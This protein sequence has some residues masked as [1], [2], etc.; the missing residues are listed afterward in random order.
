MPSQLSRS[1]KEVLSSAFPN[2]LILEEE[3][4]NY[5]GQRLFFD[6]F[7]PTLEIYVEVQGIQHTQFSPHFHA[8][9]GAFRAQKKRDKLKL[10]WCE[11][12]GK[13]LVSVNYDEVEGLTVEK[14]LE[15]VKE[16]QGG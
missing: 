15:K 14:L 12:N 8:D 3:Y 4:L 16:A 5:K 9:A 2:V 1:V 6:F 11:E 7:L 10:E 13:A